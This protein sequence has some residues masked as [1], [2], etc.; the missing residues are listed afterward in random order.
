M[1]HIAGIQVKLLPEGI[2]L[3]QQ[4]YV[5][6]IVKMAG[7]ENCN[8]QYTPM[9][10]DDPPVVHPDIPESSRILSWT[11]RKIDVFDGLHRPDIAFAVTTGPGD[12]VSR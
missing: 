8:P 1:A 11:R 6:E 5:N 10:D 4:A 3:T 9:S 2:L 12:T 7:Q